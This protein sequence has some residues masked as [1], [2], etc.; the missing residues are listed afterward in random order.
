[1]KFK[2]TELMTPAGL[3]DRQ[4]KRE[5][6]AMRLVNN[7]IAKLGVV[8]AIVLGGSSLSACANYDAQIA[9]LNTRVSAV[10]A[11]AT[12]ALQRAD[13]ANAAAQSAAAAAA[14]ANQR[15]DAL[16]TQVNTMQTTTTMRTPRG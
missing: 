16:T 3:H 15:I 4:A 12:D 11:K 2:C 8:A 7:P 14:N 6:T 1:V 13:A 9:D 5:E 10:D